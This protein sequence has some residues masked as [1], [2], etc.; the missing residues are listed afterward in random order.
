MIKIRVEAAEC[1]IAQVVEILQERFQEIEVT[2]IYDLKENRSR[3]YIDI[4]RIL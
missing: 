1:Q 3:A 2:G 4:R